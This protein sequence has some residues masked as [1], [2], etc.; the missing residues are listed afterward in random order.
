MKTLILYVTTDGQTKKIAQHIANEIEGETRL[1]SLKNEQVSA[2]KLEDA[3]KI[4]IGASVRYGHFNPI[5]KNFVQQHYEILNQ[6]KSAFFSIN[7][8]A[9]KED[10]NTPE[11]NVYTR[12][13]LERISWRPAY[14]A[15]FAGKLNYPQYTWYDRAIIRFIMKLTGGE[16]DTTKV[17]EYTDWQKVTEFAKQFN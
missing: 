2:Q 7:L 10:K 12:K 9:R 1:V 17:I 5:L 11:T 3:D 4:I 14:T 6:K 15:V 16:T 13:F 8:T